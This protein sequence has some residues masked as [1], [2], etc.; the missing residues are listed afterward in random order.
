MRVPVNPSAAEGS[1][2][3]AGRKATSLLDALQGG[4]VKTNQA[5][6]GTSS[7][8]SF[9]TQLQAANAGTQRNDTSSSRQNTIPSDSSSDNS[10]SSVDANTDANASLPSEQPTSP[11]PAPA[12]A[13]ATLANVT[14]SGHA[15]SGNASV[16]DEDTNLTSAAASQAT[17]TQFV[18]ALTFASLFMGASLQ[19]SALPA[20]PAE[21]T[22]SGIMSASV[23]ASLVSATGSA[24][25]SWGLSTLSSAVTSNLGDTT[26]SSPQASVGVIQL[27]SQK[28]VLGADWSLPS[29]AAPKVVVASAGSGA[30][31][32]SLGAIS[33]AT[34]SAAFSVAPNGAQI[35]NVTVKAGSTSPDV[36]NKDS[37]P[38]IQSVST[39]FILDEKTDQA[40]P[41]VSEE[42]TQ[43]SVAPSDQTMSLTSGAFS[44]QVQTTP[45]AQTIGS[46]STR[47]P[48]SGAESTATPLA[49]TTTN[50][51]VQAQAPVTLSSADMSHHQSMS[52]D[53]SSSSKDDEPSTENAAKS[54]VLQ[55]ATNT[56]H[57]VTFQSLVANTT[58]QT[59]TPQ[60]TTTFA[61]AEAAK[62]SLSDQGASGADLSSSLSMTVQTEDNTPV[63]LIFEGEGGL[64]TRIV[65]QS[66]DTKTA[67]H[68]AN[69][70]KDLLAALSS[71]GID[72]NG[73]KLDVVAAAVNTGDS[74]RG[75]G[76]QDSSSRPDLSGNF[77]GNTPQQNQQGGS[78]TRPWI[79]GTLSSETDTSIVPLREASTAVE[80]G[81]G[82]NITA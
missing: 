60:Q 6:V 19:S 64:A 33:G 21:A 37:A 52:G 65:L 11:A 67:E 44:A 54:P 13:D 23:G 45:F 40:K 7:S 31:L 57:P 5:T 24:D 56:S 68:L 79:Q 53:D 78:N 29:S 20:Q 1:T 14:S 9:S 42:L 27:P 17:T 15:T 72:T 61:T 35:S 10:G 18:D 25:A 38:V 76:Q 12:S 73:M 62:T 51:P 32:S 28:A 69:N 26:T 8:D 34:P 3:L 81:G 41:P 22:T 48:V 39:A 4:S 71:A 77:M 47:L 2:R 46:Q 59:Q 74:K 70:K 82:V 80:A 36:S 75:D 49:R 30:T 50:Q 66:D 63:R 55:L 58:S 43:N 16:D